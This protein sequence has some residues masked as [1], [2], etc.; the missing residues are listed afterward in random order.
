MASRDEVRFLPS[1]GDM[2]WRS[3]QPGDLSAIKKLSRACLVADGGLIIGV[4]EDFV[5]E[6]YFPDVSMGHSMAAIAPYGGDKLVA[7]AALRSDHT[8][9]EYRVSMLGQVHSA[10]R[11]HGLGTGLLKWGIETAGRLLKGCPSD[12]PHVMQVASEAFSAS[13][14]RLLERNGFRPR[15]AAHVMSLD[16]H[17][18]LPCSHMPRGVEFV[19]WEPELA[20]QFFSV[21]QAAYRERPGFPDWSQEEWLEWLDVDD[22]DF[23][24]SETLLAMHEGVPVGFIASAV[25]SEIDPTLMW[26]TQ[27]GVSPEARGRGIGS[28]LLGEAARRFQADARE[29]V[30]LDVAVDNQRAINVYERGGFRFIGRR[31]RYAKVLK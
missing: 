31:G 21:Y 17:A 29:Q 20:S 7:C 22:E 10:Y 13:G 28:A 1:H 9:D 11:N 18:P 26:V 14:E 15:Y 6:N 16:L 24:P 30:Q 3:I 4:E 19:G 5:Y 8:P 2:I 27:M 23:R 25:L 12:R